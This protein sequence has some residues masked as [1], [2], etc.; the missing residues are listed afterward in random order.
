M[1]GIVFNL[2]EDAVTD[3]HGP[4]AWDDAV[5]ASGVEGAYSAIGSYPDEQFVRLL[6]ALPVDPAARP[7]DSTSTRLVWFGRRAM[8][9]LAERYAVFFEPH[10]SIST[11]LPTLNVVIHPEVRKLYPGADVPVF[12]VSHRG[13]VVVLGYRSHRGL[14]ALARGF[15]LGAGDV[16]GEP[17]EVHE[18]RCALA[19]AE[20][21]VIVCD[22]VGAPT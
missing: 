11:F 14:C 12:D 18:E 6:G 5:D 16:F 7:D 15:V 3:E 1:K 4:D 10:R 17:V 2:L 19:G 13:E 8:P 22:P 9:F 20:S 21:C